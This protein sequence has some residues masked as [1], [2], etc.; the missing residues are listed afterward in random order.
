MANEKERVN[1]TNLTNKKLSTKIH[2]LDNLFHGGLHL[3]EFEEK[4]PNLMV[5]IRGEH[6]TNKIHLA[7][8]MCEGLND[9]IKTEGLH[10]GENNDS[11]DNPQ[12]VSAYEYT[13]LTIKEKI[14]N[15]TLA[16]DN[17][18]IETDRWNRLLD[19]KITTFLALQAISKVGDS[20]FVEKLE[21]ED[22]K[23]ILANLED[24]GMINNIKTAIE[25][26][27]SNL[28]YNS[29]ESLL[30]KIDK[31]YKKNKN[32]SDDENAKMLFVS[33]NKDEAKVEEFYYDF[34]VKRLIKNIESKANGWD[35]KKTGGDLEKIR[36]IFK[37]REFK[38]EQYPHFK[39]TTLEKAI[40]FLAEPSNENDQK[41][42]CDYD[43]NHNDDTKD[44]LQKALSS[45][46]I[47]FNTR[48]HG[49]QLRKQTKND[50]SNDT[51]LLKIDLKN[52]KLPRIDF[53][54]RD[55]LNDGNKM[56]DGRTVFYNLMTKLER[57]KDTHYNCIMIDGL[58][59]L[60]PEEIEDCPINALINLMRT[61]CFIGILNTNDNVS[62]S[63]LDSDI[64]MEL[65]NRIDDITNH[66]KK[67]LR[68]YKCLYQ[69]NT[70]GWHQY[71]M[72]NAG[73]E[74]IP[75]LHKT[76]SRRNY[77]DESTAEAML[78]LNDLT[79]N[80]WI[81]ENV[82]AKDPIE[83]N[84]EKIILENLNTLAN[85][86]KD[87]RNNYPDTGT[88]YKDINKGELFAI[89]SYKDEEAA[90][91]RA[92]KEINPEDHILFLDLK[93]S[94][95]DFWEFFG[96]KFPMKQ[97]QKNLKN[98]SYKNL[99]FFGFRAGCIYADEFLYIIEQQVSA[100]AREIQR[101]IEG[102]NPQKQIFHYYKKVHII[103]GDLN[104]LQYCYP[105][106]Y[107]EQL[108]IPTFSALTKGNYMTNY[109]Y[110]TKG[111]DSKG[112]LRTRQQL[113]AIADKTL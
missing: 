29:L 17:A 108:F 67:E 92:I 13:K 4:N 94:R 54:G 20:S 77:I 99:H 85:N 1:E 105:C 103:M 12:F 39:E 45:G 91:Y 52:K 82:N 28:N 21:F 56:A 55:Q 72:R 9:S 43:K 36:G 61:K 65:R 27:V 97:T 44:C 10:R 107:S 15:E 34:Y 110:M 8:Q 59:L 96:E 49:I 109:I 79:Y 84:D 42:I 83:S 88:K 62:L 48:T 24:E 102:P 95:K 46:V 68:I 89:S 113:T 69:K 81:N 14:A 75:S 7:M 71:K 78:P 25:N 5:V 50:D 23:T 16:K 30:E 64:I 47:Y 31:S 73:V 74:V 100:I 19:D 51:L 3:E 38:K 26:I 22:A 90:I 33:L 76:L 63:R 18:M 40:D 58:S 86:Y 32:N 6:G 53:W 111:D 60:T 101:I 80:Y 106:L 93:R 11:Q 87:F 104:L 112:S 35:D 98:I 66:T 2:G 70:Y 57:Q 41:I 37:K